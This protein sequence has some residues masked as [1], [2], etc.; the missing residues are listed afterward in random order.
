MIRCNI[1]VQICSDCSF[2]C[3]SRHM[4]GRI[5]ANV[6]DGDNGQVSVWGYLSS[7]STSWCT[8]GWNTMRI[9]NSKQKHPADIA[10]KRCAYLLLILELRQVALCMWSL[11][12]VCWFPQLQKVRCKWLNSSQSFASATV[13]IWCVCIL[14]RHDSCNLS[15]HVFK[16]SRYLTT[17]KCLQ[18]LAT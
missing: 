6:P 7:C 12:L 4:N 16:C 8:P 9:L 15:Y 5:F 11:S 10:V 14:C 18:Q 13:M 1:C 17:E 3:V 2:I